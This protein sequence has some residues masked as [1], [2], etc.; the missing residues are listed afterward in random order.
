MWLIYLAIPQADELALYMPNLWVASLSL[1][2]NL[3]G[4][5]CLGCFRILELGS[6]DLLSYL[7]NTN[8]KAHATPRLYNFFLFFF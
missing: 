3:F 7:E 1:L 6:Y 4:T 2:I 5:H 8:H